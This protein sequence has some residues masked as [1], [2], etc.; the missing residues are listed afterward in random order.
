[1]SPSNGLKS[2][3]LLELIKENLLSE[4]LENWI[5]MLSIGMLMHR[6]IKK[7]QII[8]YAS[9]VKHK[10]MSGWANLQRAKDK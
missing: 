4:G 8:S 7:E 9:L 10:L 2:S 3:K 1:M 6:P 5:Q